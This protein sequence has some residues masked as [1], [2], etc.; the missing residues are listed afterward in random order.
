MEIIS[1]VE[2]AELA[3]DVKQIA[4]QKKY[5]QIRGRVENDCN[6]S[7]AWIG[8]V[9]VAVLADAM[10]DILCRWQAC[11]GSMTADQRKR[12]LDWDIQEFRHAWFDI[13][14]EEEIKRG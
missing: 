2:S 10:S 1:S 6:A 4:L 13:L 11:S 14:A 9:P 8:D 3:H 12:M 7:A 5:E